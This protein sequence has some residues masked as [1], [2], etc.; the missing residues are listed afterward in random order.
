[1]L[2]LLLGPLS[3]QRGLLSP[4]LALAL[5]LL[6]TLLTQVG[7][8]VLWLAYGLGELLAGRRQGGR[9]GRGNRGVL[10]AAA[11]IALYSLTSLFIL[12]VLAPAYGRVALNC[13][14]DSQHPYAANSILY[15]ALN[16]HYVIPGTKQVL[17]AL[18]D[19]MARKHPGTV[20]SYLDGGFP[21]P[22]GIP[23]IPHL[24]HNDGRKL[25]LAF[26]YKDKT[27]GKPI[28]KGGAWFMGY[29]AFAPSW[30]Q[31]QA[32][33][34]SPQDGFL[35]WR[36]D[37]LQGTFENY[38]LDRART[39]DMVRFLVGSSASRQVQ[40]VFLEPYLKPILKLQS[41]KIGFAGWN[42]ARHDDHL[43]FQVN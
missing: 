30:A 42:A 37:W 35:R 8:L 18:S 36:F 26:F 25:D 5:I 3:R 10:T 39:A 27:S 33:P 13:F 40:R 14:A 6:L 23:L 28:P 9:S 24:S 43:H 32:D 21:L 20:V 4:V 15:C 16:R 7:G 12:P 1:M 31:Q 22:I 11:F 19:H 38:E 41:G 34:A 17:E 29:W 2:R